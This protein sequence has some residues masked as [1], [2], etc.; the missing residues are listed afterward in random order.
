MK[1][2]K[3]NPWNCCGQTSWTIK[4]TAEHYSRIHTKM[5]AGLLRANKLEHQ[6]N[7]GEL[8]KDL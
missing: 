1:Q 5:S 8:F 6:R 4:E 2:H 3:G 7:S